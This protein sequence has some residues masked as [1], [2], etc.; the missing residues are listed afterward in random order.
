VPQ[1]AA[2]NGVLTKLTDAL[3]W[4]NGLSQLPMEQLPRIANSYVTSE[5]SVAR[6]LATAFPHCWFL[7]TDGLNY[8]GQAVTGGKKSGAGPLALKRELREI[9]E[10][11]RTRQAEL[12]RAEE[13]LRQLER[14]IAKLSEE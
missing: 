8:H 6:E 13:D 2:E 1:P 14:E 9:V 3:R 4:T 11:E 7:T 5:R 10:R 12:D